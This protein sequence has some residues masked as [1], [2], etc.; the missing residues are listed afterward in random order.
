MQFRF[1][2]SISI[3]GRNSIDAAPGC[4][5]MCIVCIIPCHAGRSEQRW[6]DMFHR[7]SKASLSVSWYSSIISSW[8]LGFARPVHGPGMWLILIRPTA[9]ISA[10]VTVTPRDLP[11]VLFGWSDCTQHPHLME[12]IQTITCTHI[13]VHVFFFVLNLIKSVKFGTCV[14]ENSAALRSN[15]WTLWYRLQTHAHWVYQSNIVRQN[16]DVSQR[17][18]SAA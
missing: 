5:P 6:S 7:V 1:L 8:Y 3:I 13:V 18:V 15:R 11:G 2:W 16:D 9:R 17:Q 4:G 12:S 10:F 14:P